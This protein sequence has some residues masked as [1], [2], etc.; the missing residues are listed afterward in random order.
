MSIVTVYTQFGYAS[1][2][3]D[4]YRDDI[5]P[6]HNSDSSSPEKKEQMMMQHDSAS[7]AT[8]LISTSSTGSLPQGEKIIEVQYKWGVGFIQ[9]GNPM[10]KLVF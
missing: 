10:I 2:D 1:V 9:V 7:S 8:S 6:S 5:L 4:K 3:I